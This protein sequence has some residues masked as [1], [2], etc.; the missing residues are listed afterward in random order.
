MG[1]LVTEAAAQSA[2]L[3]ARKRSSAQAVSRPK[4]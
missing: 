1:I 2:A 3:L 4:P